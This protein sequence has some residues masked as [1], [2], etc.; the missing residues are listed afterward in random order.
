MKYKLPYSDV[1]HLP[2]AELEKLIAEGVPLEYS[3]SLTD[4]L[5]G[6]LDAG[7]HL[8]AM[9]EDFHQG[10]TLSAYMPTY[11]ATRALKP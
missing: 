5:G 4:Q 3:H 11:L 6:Q 2:K 10:V 1:E 9:Y 7:F 8:A